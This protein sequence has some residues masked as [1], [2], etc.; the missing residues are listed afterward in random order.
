MCTNSL[1]RLSEQVAEGNY[2]NTDYGNAPGKQAAQS[3]LVQKMARDTPYYK[4][5]KAKICTFWLR[6]ACT[7]PDC[8]FRPCNGDTDMPEL[9]SDASMRKQNI[10]DRY[11]GKDDPV[12]QKMMKRASK[13]TGKTFAQQ[14]AEA[15]GESSG[16][17]SKGKA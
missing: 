17:E 10:S 4:K 2:E 15:R 7:R 5:N 13:G 12:A 14:A 16:K 9:S 1:C 6:N 11:H 3:N 8:P